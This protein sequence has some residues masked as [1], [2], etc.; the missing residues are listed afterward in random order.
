MN[1]VEKRSIMEFLRSRHRRA[2]KKGK[3]VIISEGCERLSVGRKQ[4]IRL[5]SPLNV[6]RPK[7]SGKGRPSKYQ[8]AEFKAALRGVWR[9]TRYLCGRR[10]RE[11]IPY[12]LEAIEEEQGKF[13][14][15]VR[16]RLLSISAPTI[17]RILKPYKVK[18]GISFTRSGGFRDEIPIQENI[19]DIK[20]PGFMETDTVAHCG[21]SM[22]GEFINTVTMVD[23]AT[24]WTEARAAFG[25]GS[26]ATLDAVKD[27]EHKLP[28]QILG[29]DADNGGEVLNQQLFNYFHTERIAKG[30]PPVAVTRSR[31]YKKNDNA[32]VEQRNDSIAR[33]YL[34]YDRI[35]YKE[36]VPLIN[37]YYAEILCP[38]INHFYPC[39]KLADKVQI[40]S[41]T[42]RIY[43]KPMTP[44]ARLMLSEHLS[45]ERKEALKLAHDKLNPVK[46]VR[47]EQH[48]RRLIDASLRKLKTGNKISNTL[49]T[50]KLWKPL[51]PPHAREQR[52]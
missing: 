19:W 47:L 14:L 13:K 1:E 48:V 3:S 21:G 33:K 23:I 51:I 26:N 10:L 4:V 16:E 27:I 12:W 32:H 18:K 44:Y 36:L 37:Y 39:F 50:Y 28:F 25:R 35:G 52:F 22:F 17:D 29:Y 11:A 34:G 7:K 6:G 15:D 2:T 24:I 49:P 9:I 5:L 40:K 43:N 42:R 41:R 38:L 31:A 30:I 46:L 8:D 45:T 20:I